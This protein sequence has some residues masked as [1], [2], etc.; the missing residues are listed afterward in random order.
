MWY[1]YITEYYSA[2]KKNKIMPFAA[3]WMELEILILSEVSHKEKNSIWYHLYLESNLWHIYTFPQK[4]NSWTWRT[5]LWLWVL[6]F[7]T[8][9]RQHNGEQWKSTAFPLNRWSGSGEWSW[10]SISGC[11][12]DRGPVLALSG[13]GQ[14]LLNGTTLHS[15]WFPTQNVHAGPLRNI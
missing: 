8:I 1:I 10:G 9:E 3:T 6:L 11:H 13:W 12:C 15:K 14:G 4:R 5:D 7:M 2:I